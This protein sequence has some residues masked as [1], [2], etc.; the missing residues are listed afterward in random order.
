MHGCKSRT[1]TSPTTLSPD[2]HLVLADLQAHDG[3]TASWDWEADVRFARAAGFAPELV[4]VLEEWLRADTRL[5]GVLLIY[6]QVVRPRVTRR[7]LRALRQL[8]AAGLV[9]SSWC[10]TGECGQTDFGV[11]R[12]RSYCLVATRTAVRHP[13]SKEQGDAS[14]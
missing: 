10:G 13:T 14:S 1:S 5:P 2:A 12:M 6:Y 4:E 9:R 3:L 8:V 7:R 11:N